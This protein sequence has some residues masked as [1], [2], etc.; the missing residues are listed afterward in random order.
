MSDYIL[1]CCSTAD[2]PY[3]YFNK[4]NI[5]FVCFHYNIDGEEYPDDLGQTMSFEEFYGKIASGAMPTTSQVNVGQFINFFEPYLKEG[6]DILHISLSTGLSGV[7]NSACIAMEELLLKY[8]ERKIKIVDSLGASSGYGLLVDIAAD[9]RDNNA[10]IEE[11]HSFVEENKLN[12][13]HWF[14]STDLTH[15]KRGGRISATSAAVGTLLNIC[16]LLN[17][18]YDGKLTPRTKIRG[19][20]HVIS[21]IVHMMEAHAQDGL[22]YSGKCFIS[23]S[24]CYD[25]ARR[26][27]DLVEEKFVNLNG[28]VMINSVGTVIGSH[29]GPGT[30]ALFFLGDKRTNSN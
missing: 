30:V 27:A 29:T 18:S 8:P 10:T 9:M 2:M 14:F 24:A 5:P 13:H 21:E 7:Y 16:P 12:V 22:N 25:D 28:K 15:Y 11:T 17:M 19:K 4:R 23:N 3:E 6:K 26:V 20:K 1:T